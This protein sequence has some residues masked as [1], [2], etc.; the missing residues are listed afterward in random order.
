MGWFWWILGAA[1]LLYCGAVRLLAGKMAFAAVPAAGGVL[2][3][4]LGTGILRFPGN[5]VLGWI[6]G[7]GVLVI[8]ILIFLEAG[9]LLRARRL[10]APAG[11]PDYTI[12][13]GCGLRNGETV[14]RTMLERLEKARAVWQ[15]EPIILSGGQS[16]REKYPEAEVM[17]RWLMEKGIPPEK[18][19][20]E[21]RS[22]NTVQNLRFTRDIIEA[23]A[24]LPV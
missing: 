12:V 20:Q 10:S 2:C 3:I 1:V 15:G 9:I 21:G 7:I 8:V 4:L 23:D 13:L 24:G 6:S 14:S 5:P 22:R 16:E 17:A 11:K 18:L 19:M